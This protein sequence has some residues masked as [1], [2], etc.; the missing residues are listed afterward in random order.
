[1]G[2]DLDERDI[3][4]FSIGYAKNEEGEVYNRCGPL[5]R[6]IQQIIICLLLL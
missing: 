4:I 6:F 5:N 2:R 1:M 3:T